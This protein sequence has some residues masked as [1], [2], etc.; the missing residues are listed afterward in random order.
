MSLSN[1]QEL[2]QIRG[3]ILGVLLTDAR[4]AY[5]RT[6]AECARLVDVP[7][8][9]YAAFEHGTQTPTLSQLEVLAYFFNVPISHFWGDKTLSA[10]RREAEVR[11]KAPQVIALRDK[12]IGA[13]LRSL[14][15]E[16]GL[17]VGEL[18]EKTGLASEQIEAY[19]Q[20]GQP[21]PLSVL[22]S[23]ANALR[24]G[25]EDLVDEHGPV[26]RWL[27]CQEEFDGFASLPDE[28]RKF[29][30]KPINR[31]YLELAMRL[32]DLPVDRLRGIAE[33]ILEITY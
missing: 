33:S 24:A 27:R 20:A 25:V 23:L 26:G 30:L 32:S 16:A 11:E 6:V 14:R 28:M 22:Q 21:L 9:T 8:E 17:S 10:A 1:T 12:M 13:A 2:L 29:I 4:R 18:A 7:E 15:E 3:R 31:S 5:G 19:E